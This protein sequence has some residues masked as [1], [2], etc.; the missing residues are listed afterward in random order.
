MFRS[1]AAMLSDVFWQHVEPDGLGVSNRAHQ[2]GATG[3][4]STTL[5]MLDQPSQRCRTKTG[6]DQS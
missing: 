3:V 6:D 1:A 2:S 5:D 4:D